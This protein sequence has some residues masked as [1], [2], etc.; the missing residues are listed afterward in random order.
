MAQ[1]GFPLTVSIGCKSFVEAP[2]TALEALRVA[3]GLLY[4]AKHR[5][6]NCVVFA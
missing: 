5:G 3:D 4:Q 6:K 1:A 2:K